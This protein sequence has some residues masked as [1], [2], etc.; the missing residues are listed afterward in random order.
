MLCKIV[1]LV[2]GSVRYDA[3]DEQAPR[4]HGSAVAGSYGRLGWTNKEHHGTPGPGHPA[5]KRTRG[6]QK[7][8]ELEE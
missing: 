6:R 8:G 2:A 1:R 5:N 4:G 7:W 3:G